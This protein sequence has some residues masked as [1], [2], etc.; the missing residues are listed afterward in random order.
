MMEVNNVNATIE[1]QLLIVNEDTNLT[2]IEFNPALE[3]IDMYAL[4]NELRNIA[5]YLEDESN[6][7]VVIFKGLSAKITIATEIPEADFFR[8]WEKV[9]NQLEK[10]P[11]VLIAVLNGA[12]E[13]FMMQLALCCDYRIATEDSYFIANELEKGFLPG[14]TTFY[15][16]K[17]VGMGL[18][19]R[20]II[21]GIPLTASTAFKEGVVD[22]M[23]KVVELSE[24]L[25][26]FVKRVTPKNMKAFQLATRLLR[27]SY[28]NSY[29]TALG[30]YLAAQ[31][32]CIDQ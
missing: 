18:A 28:A 19:R 27:E 1:T 20:T 6:S 3:T 16:T 32:K 29:E 23:Y 5:N 9:L 22:S 26:A 30:H 31:H 11:K 8:R 12:C 14:I 2:T 13:N 10:L 4:L 25:D 21:A 24:V 15:L 17:Y 7:A